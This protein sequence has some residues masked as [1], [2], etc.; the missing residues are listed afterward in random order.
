MG[1]KRDGVLMSAATQKRPITRAGQNKACRTKKRGAWIPAI[2]IDVV[3]VVIVV[4]LIILNSSVTV[5]HSIRCLSSNV[6]MFN[7]IRQPRYSNILHTGVKAEERDRERR[8]P[9]DMPYVCRMCWMD[10]RFESAGIVFLLL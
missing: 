2:C 1:M 9:S 7:A 10:C 3:V 5:N 8:D 4:A 6:H